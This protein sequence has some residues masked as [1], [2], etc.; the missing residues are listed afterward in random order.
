[1]PKSAPAAPRPLPP[2]FTAIRLSDAD[3]QIWRDAV[4]AR[5]DAIRQA[6]HAVMR[7]KLAIGDA[8]E[9]VIGMTRGMAERYH[10]DARKVWT[11]HDDNR[12]T[13][14]AGSV[15]GPEAPR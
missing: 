6:E 13:P 2:E 4:E 1:M 9:A 15:P 12:L 10:F 8:T 11:L 3:A 5:E 14:A 7:A